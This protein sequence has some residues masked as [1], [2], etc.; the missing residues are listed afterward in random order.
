MDIDNLVQMYLGDSKTNLRE[1]LTYKDL[2][3]GSLVYHLRTIDEVIHFTT[4]V[5]TSVG[6]GERRVKVRKSSRTSE[7]ELS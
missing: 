7:V 4:E 2:T 3:L 5:G 1:D 6:P